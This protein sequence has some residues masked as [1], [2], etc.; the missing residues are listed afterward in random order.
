MLIVLP[1]CHGCAG[2]STNPVFSSNP[3]L[4]SVKP[5]Y[6][7]NPYKNGRFV[8]PYRS[9]DNGRESTWNYATWKLNP[10]RK[11]VPTE[12]S[13]DTPVVTYDQKAHDHKPHIV[14]L[15]HATILLR[16]NDRSILVDP[17]LN[18][19]RLFHGSRLGRLPVSPNRLSIDF[20]LATHAHRDHLDKQTVKQLS[21]SS[22]KAFTPLKMGKL[23]RHWRPDISVQEAGWYQT[24]NTESDISITLLP[25][26]H[27]S[28]R[29][30]F[31]TNAVLWGSYMIRTNEVTIFIAGDTGYADHF[32]E[33]GKLFDN[34]DYA[35]LPIGSY[36]PDHIHRNSHMTPEEALQ[37]FEDLQATTMIPVH[38]GTF[39]L[40]DEPIDEPLQR[41]ARE[42]DR[43]AIPASSVA[44]LAIGE[45]HYL[46]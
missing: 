42:I 27:W 25:A 34:I 1:L 13:S 18:T 19:P 12:T 22:I 38:Y 2:M 26:Y 3:N 45:A 9:V 37:A 16:L 28:R 43:K 35:I 29:N 8:G 20:L 23:L 30:L 40:S 21:G 32:K 7:G 4:P 6:P 14:W 41:L 24:F 17:I 5:E 10:Y 11:R 33:I 36:E 31:D 39:D 46:R 44:T 15:G